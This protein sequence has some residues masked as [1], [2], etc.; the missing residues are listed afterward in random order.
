MAD[1]AG[2][3]FTNLLDNE[4]VKEILASNPQMAPK[5]AILVYDTVRGTKPS[6]AGHIEIK[7]EDSGIDRSE[8]RRVGKEC[9]SRC[10]S[11]WSPYH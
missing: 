9:C 2:A 8:E 1:L 11:R 5:G 10:R 6:P 4:N 3:G 7:T